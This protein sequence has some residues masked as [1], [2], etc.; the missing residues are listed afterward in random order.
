MLVVKES[1]KGWKQLHKIYCQLLGLPK[2]QMQSSVSKRERERRSLGGS[3]SRGGKI[4]GCA[5]CS[6]TVYTKRL[7]E[8]TLTEDL[9]PKLVQSEAHKDDDS[10][11]DDLGRG[12]C[13]RRKKG[14]GKEK[15][16]I[17]KQLS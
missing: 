7:Q 5:W 4:A 6:S 17:R 11:S 2:Y 3:R 13:K 10:D 8:M 9:I 16:P 15:V 1:K 14:K 12:E